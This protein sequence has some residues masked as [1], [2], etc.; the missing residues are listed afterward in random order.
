MTDDE[1]EKNHARVKQFIAAGS[2]QRV[3]SVQ[4]LSD[5]VCMADSA[6]RYHIRTGLLL[7]RKDERGRWLIPCDVARQFANIVNFNRVYR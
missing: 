4:D 5:Q 3:I 1:F 2:P 6:I 7:A